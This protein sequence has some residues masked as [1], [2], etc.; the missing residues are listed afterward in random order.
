[1]P[2]N[3]TLAEYDLGGVDCPLC[4]NTGMIIERGPGLLELHT[5]EC[6]CMRERRSLRSLRKAGMADMATRYTMDAYQTDTGMR[7]KIKR[8]A[9]EFIAADSGWFFIA[10][11]SGSGKTHICTAI[12]IG[13]MQQKA[14]EIYFMPWRD[15]S[16]EIKAN[17]KN[18][19]IYQAKIKRLKRV[20]VLYIDDFLK[21]SYTDADIK[22]AF[23]I[24]NTRYNDTALRT[25]I[26]SELPI[27]EILKIDE[28]LG[29]RIYERSRA[30]SVLA[31]DENWRLR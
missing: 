22:L 9:Q 29:G 2:S 14:S 24:L 20:P 11:R 13:L 23:E 25:I 6:S 3:E 26:S 16:T 18:Q 10:G 19:E 28:A 12:C 15:D 5:H 7:A 17:V 31:P 4:N 30:F 21:G 27:N 1:M 8:I